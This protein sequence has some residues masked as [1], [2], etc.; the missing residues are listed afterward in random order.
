MKKKSQRHELKITLI[1]RIDLIIVFKIT[2][3]KNRLCGI[4][5]IRGRRRRWLALAASFGEQ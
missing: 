4:T 5:F 3:N 2:K 1:L